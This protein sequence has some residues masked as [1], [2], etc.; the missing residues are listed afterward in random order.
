[1]KTDIFSKIK[2][3]EE[4]ISKEGDSID[5]PLFYST[6]KDSLNTAKYSYLKEC[7]NDI[8]HY[9]E[10][11]KD[12]ADKVYYFLVVW[13]VCLLGLLIASASCKEFILSQGVLIT[14]CGGTTI[15]TIGLV[16]FVVKGLFNNHVNK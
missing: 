10:M 12:F 7:I 14:L 3:A 6:E 15:S 5:L 4:N 16:G 1:M 8:I 9:R 13:C 11:R 2:N